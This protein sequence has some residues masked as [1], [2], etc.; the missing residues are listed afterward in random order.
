MTF[1]FAASHKTINSKKQLRN[2]PLDKEKV[3]F[4]K[5]CKLSVQCMQ[6]ENLY[7]THMDN[8]PLCT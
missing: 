8:Y 6:I 1:P 4:S 5:T 2:V 3:K 7:N